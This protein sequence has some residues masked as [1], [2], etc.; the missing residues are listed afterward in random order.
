[1]RARVSLT[2]TLAGDDG[3]LLFVHGRKDNPE[4]LELATTTEGTVRLGNLARAKKHGTTSIDGEDRF[5]LYAGDVVRVEGTLIDGD[6]SERELRAK[7]IAMPGFR[8]D[9]SE[10]G[11]SRPARKESRAKKERADA[12]T[13]P[14]GEVRT[15]VG[16]ARS[17][18]GT[19]AE[20]LF[21]SV[22]MKVGEASSAERRDTG[23]IEFVAED[24]ARYRVEAI[25]NATLVGDFSLAGPY[26]ELVSN[27][28]AKLFARSAPGDHVEVEI[29][30]KVLCDGDAITLEAEVLPDVRFD[31]DAVAN[32]DFRSAPRASLTAA[33]AIRVTL[34]GAHKA[35]VAAP[36]R[37]PRP[38]PAPLPDVRAR[39]PL[40]KSTAVYLALGALALVGS[41]A[42]GTVLSM[43]PQRAALVPLS[44]MGAGFLL[45]GVNRW[46]RARRHASFVTIAGRSERKSDKSAVWGYRADPWFLAF[47]AFGAGITYL[48][49]APRYV[50]NLGLALVALSVLH[51]LLLA[52]QESAF[53]RFAS[54]VLSTPSADPRSGKTVFIE[55]TARNE[56]PPLT[57]RVEFY[58]MTEVT[59]STRDDGSDRETHTSVVVDRQT[60]RCESFELETDRGTIHVDPHR[61]QVAFASRAWIEHSAAS[62]YDETPDEDARVC[63]VARCA[64]EGESLSA[65]AGGDESM[66]LWAGSRG[67]LV[68]ALWFARARVALV[69]AVGLV[70]AAL[71]FT[72]VP[73]AAR[74]R[75]EG[76]VS[77][78]TLTGVSAGDRCVLR[79][80]AY[81]YHRAPRCTV[82]LDCGRARLYGGYGMGQMDCVIPQSPR[83]IEL[84]GEDASRYDG[85]DALR[86]DLRALTVTHESAANGAVTRITL[87]SARP[88]L[89]LF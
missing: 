50:G 27:P 59:H 53:R 62:A 4:W 64:A 5:A 78:T 72:L 87:D 19:T 55:G 35:P 73:Y 68:K 57:R 25:A 34:E 70:P 75:A 38:Q 16:R 71:G 22:T 29:S 30:G 33:R 8:L 79:V 26:G 32:A 23:A 24:G 56:R 83:S 36:P 89:A 46:L 43:Q 86:F 45:V 31:G 76:T 20:V 61:A 21:A 74:Y 40:E 11:A 88:A 63:L 48:E 66:F 9:G 60:T 41:I 13:P 51:A 77:S 67:A 52:T 58:T 39:Y 14:R 7:V 18:S 17:P 85:D 49:P 42:A 12:A 84:S 10:D 28:V 37:A 81:H 54:R 82:T 3:S 2:G 6:R 65:Q 1:M 15:L 69:L 80:L 44:S 47:Y